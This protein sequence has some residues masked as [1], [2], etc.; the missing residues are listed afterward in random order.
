MKPINLFL[1]VFI[2]SLAKLGAQTIRTQEYHLLVG[3]YAAEGKPNGIHSLRFNTQSGDFQPGLPPLT[4][5][6]NAS[7]LAISTDRQNVYAISD[8]PGGGKVNAF[9]FDPASGA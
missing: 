2:L 6:A 4:E 5:L 9:A 7:Y 1:F 8:G 3:T